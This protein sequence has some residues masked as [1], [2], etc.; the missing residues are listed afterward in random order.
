[1]SAPAGNGPTITIMAEEEPI[2]IGFPMVAAYHGQSALAMAA[3]VFQVQRAAIA[4][5]P[6]LL[7]TS[8]STNRF[9]SQ[10]ALRAMAK[11]SP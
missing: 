6:P 8:R 4:L 7:S 1:M 5:L 9:D 11:A 3:I 10:P 2:E